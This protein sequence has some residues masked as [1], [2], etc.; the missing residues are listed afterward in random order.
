[1]FFI[2]F[3]HMKTKITTLILLFLLFGLTSNLKAQESATPLKGEGITAFLKRHGYTGKEAKELFIEINKKKLG[4]D[5]GLL[6]GKT[7]TLPS[8]EAVAAAN[9][10]KTVTEPLFGKDLQE[11]TIT[12]Q[13]LS[14][15]CFYLVSGHGGP[16]P[17][18]VTKVDGVE[19]H[20]DE[21]AYDIILRLA[22]NLMERGAKV[23]VIIQDSKDGI[24]DDK[25]LSNSN[26]ELCMGDVIPKNQN[27]RLKQ[28]CNAI[29][30]LAKKDTEKYKRAVFIHVDSRRVK[31]QI[32]VFL[33][34]APNSTK[35]KDFA[36]KIR[37]TIENKY[38]QHQPNRG[39]KGTVSDRGLYV[40]RRSDPVAAFLELGNIQNEKDRK[41][42]VISSNR[43]ALAN[44][45]CHGILAD[46][47]EQNSK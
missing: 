13:E 29:N 46:Y 2:I 19:L 21:Y 37:V 1:M 5:G 16:D 24:R 11:V 23:H 41:R 32:D 3:A 33:Y 35:G 34:H 4:K 25:Y 36:E 20:E 31:E 45:I 18:A 39:F 9:K 12:S 28:R 38:D 8:A 42:L 15:A 6:L 27:K 40:L 7:Y 30:K 43:Q 14:D 44:W 10:P 22:R 17:G 47:K 26:R